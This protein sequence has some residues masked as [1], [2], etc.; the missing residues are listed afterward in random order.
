MQKIA[1]NWQLAPIVRVNSALPLNPLAG[2]DN[3]LN[4]MTNITGGGATQR[5]NLIGDPSAPVQSYDHWFN[6][7]AFLPNVAGQYGNA[8]KNSLR[9]AAQTNVNVA[10]SRR[11]PVT[12]RQSVEVRAETFNL[13]NLVNPTATALT[14]TISSPQFGKITSAADPRI[15]QFALKYVF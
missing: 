11:F 7:A 9:G 3:Y 14:G 12:E 10:V 2:R 4:G 13:P 1:G 8:G 5:P 15:L 6:Q